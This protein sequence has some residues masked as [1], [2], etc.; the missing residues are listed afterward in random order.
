[1]R[2]FR[3]LTVVSILLLAS[4]L[5]ACGGGG[6]PGVA[7]FLPA[8]VTPQDLAACTLRDVATGIPSLGFGDV[9]GR[10]QAV[11]SDPL[12]DFDTIFDDLR[13]SPDHARLAVVARLDSAVGNVESLF[14]VDPT[15]GEFVTV[16]GPAIDG[17]GVGAFAWAP[18]STQLAYQGASAAGSPVF[19]V[20]PDGTD[21]HMVSGTIVAGGNVSTFAWSP[22]ATKIAMVIDA[23]VDNTQEVYVAPRDGSFR[24]KISGASA[25]PFAS[26]G[27]PAWSPDSL[28]VAYNATLDAPGAL[29]LFTSLASGSGGRTQMHPVLAGSSGVSSF[30][31]APDG[32]RLAYVADQLANGIFEL[33]TTRADGTGNVRVSGTMATGG[34]VVNAFL[35]GVLWAPDA[36]RLAYVAD[37]T[38]NDVFE[39][40]TVVPDGAVPTV[41][42]SGPMV[43]GGDVGGSIF[44]LSTDDVAWSPDSTRLAYFA[45]QEVGGTVELY[46]TPAAS[47]APVRLSASVM[48]TSSFA[49]RIRWT[50]DSLRIVY[51]AR[52]L[53]AEEDVFISPLLAGPPVALVPA[54]AGVVQ[55][56]GGPPLTLAGDRVVVFFRSDV[57][58]GDGVRSFH[59]VTHAEKVVVQP[60]APTQVSRLEVR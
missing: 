38:T 26:I 54:D 27:G 39:L 12:F 28:R 40:Y 9:E 56:F 31:W 23:E 16:G 4:C 33:F 48:G 7:T 35:G 19:V 20:N 59:L 34:D 3:S 41:K 18:D 49:T 57:P 45:D 37:Q 52:H 13:W 42:V 25:A 51:Q 36:S 15:T 14:V 2:E 1:M 32:T 58:D 5:A 55:L 60:A 10:G 29:E 30:V 21:R 24:V 8:G 6:G 17:S 43:S 47:S 50:S 46:V 11:L 22:D 53:T 44:G